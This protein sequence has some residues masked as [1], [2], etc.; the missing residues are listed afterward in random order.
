MNRLFSKT[1]LAQLNFLILCTL[2]A[3]GQEPIVITAKDMFNQPGEYYRTYANS[4]S[5]PVTVNQLIQEPGGP[6]FWNFSSESLPKDLI[7]RW[8][9]IDMAETEFQSNFPEATFAERKTVE[10]TQE[11]ELQFMTQRENEGRIVF[12]FWS[13]KVDAA[14]PVK[15]MTPPINDFPSEIRYEDTWTN[16]TSWVQE[17]LGLPIIYY[18]TSDF[19]VD[20][21]GLLQLP[22]DLSFDNTLRVNEFVTTTIAVDINGTGDYQTISTDYNRFYYW[23]RPG[24]GIAA[25]MASVQSTS[26]VPEQFN[27]ALQFARTF[28]TNKVISEDCPEALPV[29]DLTIEINRTTALLSWT[30]VNCVSLYRVEYSQNPGDSSSWQTL[31][32]SKDNFATDFNLDQKPRTFYRVVSIK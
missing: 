6:R 22:G 2:S 18:R 14:D 3:S 23:L 13:P 29:E 5:I 19:K 32:E 9:I 4:S 21:Y 20:A 25:Q 28:E 30:K 8:D 12:G 10:S 15:E 1:V 27:L 26:V 11:T 7:Y 31:K 24:M 17:V 16:S